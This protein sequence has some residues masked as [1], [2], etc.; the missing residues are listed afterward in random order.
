MI[1]QYTTLAPAYRPKSSGTFG[2]PA[3]NFNRAPLTSAHTIY[4]SRI[5]NANVDINLLVAAAA[6]IFPVLSKLT[7][8]IEQPDV[9]ALQQ[10]LVHEV[11]VFETNAQNANFQAEKILIARYIL[12][13]TVDEIILSTV[14]GKETWLPYKLLITFQ[15]E[16]DGDERFFTILERLAESPQQNIELLELIYICLS[17]GFQ[18]KYRFSDSGK[19]QLELIIEDLYQK[20]RWQRGELE[21]SLLISAPSLEYNENSAE[22]S[23]PIWLVIAFYIALTLTI[24]AAYNY[25]ATR[26]LAAVYQQLNHLIS[27]LAL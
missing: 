3:I 10:M 14:W 9:D 6:A 27:Q 18:G 7:E 11:K 2:Q 16:S 13:T 8:I 17:L 26:N 4:R 25:L 5:L 1:E 20:I 21:K 23:L 22:D 19:N 12:C 24:Y 15:R